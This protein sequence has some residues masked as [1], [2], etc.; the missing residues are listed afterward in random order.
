MELEGSFRWSQEPSI[1][2]TLNLIVAPTTPQAGEP[3]PVSYPHLI[4]KYIVS[5]PP[6]A[7]RFPEK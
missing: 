7:T 1:G 5:H 3:I 6:Y 4:S 2:G